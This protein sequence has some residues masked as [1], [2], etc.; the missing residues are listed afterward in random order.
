MIHSKSHRLE[1]PEQSLAFTWFVW[2]TWVKKKNQKLPCTQL[3]FL[4]SS[5]SGKHGKREK[6]AS[7]DSDTLVAMGEVYQLFFKG[8]VLSFPNLLTALLSHTQLQVNSWP[9]QA[10]LGLLIDTVKKWR[11][12]LALPGFI[13]T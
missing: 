12:N 3:G 10:D 4:L 5:K 9:H 1:G 13:S 11:E 8:C 2:S 6:L 7:L